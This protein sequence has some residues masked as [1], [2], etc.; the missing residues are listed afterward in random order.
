[1]RRVM[2]PGGA[3]LCVLAGFAAA[4]PDPIANVFFGFDMMLY[5]VATKWACGGEQEA[6]LAAI[7]AL[8]EAFPEDAAAADLTDI[9]E[10]LH[11]MSEQA[12]GL[13]SLFGKPL[14]DAEERRVCEAAPRLRFDWVTPELFRSEDQGPPP[15]DQADAWGAYWRVVET[16]H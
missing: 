2:G 12:D 14:T 15:D 6:D 9:V 11:G 16:L 8:I 13:E 4:E 1:M 10:G 3:C 5:P 7:R